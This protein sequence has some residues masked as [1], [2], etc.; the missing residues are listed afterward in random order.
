MFDH[1]AGD[2]LEIGGGPYKG[3]VVPFTIKMVPE[4]DIDGG[5]LIVDPPEGLLE[6]PEDE[7]K[8]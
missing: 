3:L 5:L 4:V 8:P 7:A 2:V 6:L 1:G